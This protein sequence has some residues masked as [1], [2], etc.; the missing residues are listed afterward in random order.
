M[1]VIVELREKG[2]ENDGTSVRSHNIRCEGRRYKG[3]Y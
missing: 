3:V 2:K 1:F